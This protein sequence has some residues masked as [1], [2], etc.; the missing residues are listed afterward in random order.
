MKKEETKPN[1]VNQ[2]ANH[3]ELVDSIIEKVKN[4]KF[5]AYFFC[6]PMNSPSGGVGVLL[7]LATYLKQTGLDV[8]LI[9]EP[10]VDQ[11]AS[12]EETNKQKK[13]VTVFEKFNPTWMDFSIEEL[14]IIPLG[15]KTIT[16]VDKTTAECQ[17]L[18]LEPEDFLFIPEGFPDVMKKT[19]QV[20]CKRIVVA[21]SWFYILN[22]LNKGEKWQNF[23]V[24]DVISVSDAITEYLTTIMPGLNIKK[25]SQGINREIFKLP[26][27]ASEKYP[28]IAF[29]TS[30][31]PENRL[32]TFNIIKTFYAFYPHLKFIRFLELANYTREEFAEKLA[33]C[34]FVLYT[35]DI[36]GF[37]TLPLEAMACGTHV[38]GWS[39][40]GG[41]EYMNQNNGFWANNGDIFQTAEL[42]GIAVDKWLNGEMDVKQIQD[43]YETTLNNYTLEKEKEQ[44][45]NIINE[46]KNERINELTGLKK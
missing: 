41:K 10:R 7:R 12:Y 8:K 42:L 40:Y 21:Q 44:F 30:R 36:A 14:E 37:G 46:F 25:F 29:S 19:M 17:P 11:R 9:Y 31:G 35:D 33:S 27:K 1:N 6:P 22:A 38:V 16:F 18:R 23:G 4:N 3:N 24:R 2:E 5:K 43:S 45:L 39:A 26:K 34:A 32:K 20:A 13:Q 15:D 28:M